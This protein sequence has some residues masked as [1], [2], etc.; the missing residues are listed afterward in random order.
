VNPTGVGFGV[1]A[2]LSWGGGDFGGGLASRRARPLATVVISQAVGLAVAIAILALVAEP[3]P[4]LVS[5]A[6]SIAAGASGM[7]CLVALYTGLATRPMGPISAVATVV[8]AAVPVIVGGLTGDRLRPQ[9]VAGIFLAVTAIVFVTR[10]VEAGTMRIGRIGLGLALL[11]GLG[12]AGFFVAMGQA[13]A[14]GGAT[15]WPLVVT[16]TASLVLAALLTIGRRQVGETV[17]SVSPLMLVVGPLDMA[18]NAF[19]LLAAGRGALSLAVVVSSQYPAVTTV[20]ARLFLRQRLARLQI[21][22]IAIALLGIALIS[23]P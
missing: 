15:W 2:A 23:A 22:G 3:N 9:D 18:G 8:G 6:W 13:R 16:R 20:L 11:S 1:G 19:F 4:G 21:A 10:P 14:A 17:R 12:A 7:V 5:A